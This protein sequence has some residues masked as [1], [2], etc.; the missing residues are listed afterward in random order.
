MKFP[1]SRQFD[2][3]DCGP[4]CIVM[5]S[6]YY[7]KNISI[8]NVRDKAY[9]N[10]NGVNLLGLIDAAHSL[11]F[12][13][14]AKKI[15]MEDLVNIENTPCIL[16][17]NN[18][19]FVVLYKIKKNKY[20]IADP[21]YGKI[22]Y[23]ENELLNNWANNTERKG[24]ILIIKPSAS[25]EKVKSNRLTSFLFLRKY[26]KN[27][28]VLSIQL[29][30]GLLIGSIL[31]LFF[32][33]L[34]QFIV[35]Y[36]IPSKNISF[37]QIILLAQIMLVVSRNIVEIIRRWILLHIST[38]INLSLLSDFLVK[39]MKLSMRFF[40]SKLV[41]DL[42]R[43]IEDHKR[44]E[45]FLTQSI[46]NLFFSLITIAVFSIVLVIYD[47]KIFA[48]FLIGSLL[49]TIWIKLFLKKRAELD[50]K[51]FSQMSENQNSL[52]QLIYGMQEIKLTG[53]EQQKLGEWENI[54]AELFQIKKKSL[55]LNQWLQT[56]AILI[57]EIKNVFITITSAI[58]VINGEITLGGMLSIQYI[59]GQMHGPIEQ[60]VLFI[61]QAQDAHLSLERMG[62]IHNSI[63]EEK[64]FS[65]VH[66][67]PEKADIELKKTFFSYG[68]IKAEPI[69]NNLSLL[70]PY[71]KTTAIVG[72]SGSGKT[73]LIKLLLG[74]YYPQEGSIQ[75]GGICFDKISLQE[76]R[77]HCG[78][79]MQDGYLFN[80]TI[81]KNIAPGDNEIDMD[82][83]NYAIRMASLNDYIDALPQKADTKIGNTGRGLSQ[84]QKQR[85]L[86]ARA[87]YK[88]PEYIFFDEATNALDSE[89]ESVIMRNLNLFFKNKTVVIVAHRLSTVKNADQIVVMKKGTI[90][91]IGTHAALI[92]ERGVY[93]N[94][95]KEQ[96]TLDC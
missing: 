57:N 26:I 54:Q 46:V 10:R 16:H 93:Y 19:H 28:K 67:I 72:L 39:M 11:G 45:T 30:V 9:I 76:W 65:G 8:E 23:S 85:L 38:R 12:E 68:N 69:I 83:I 56:G 2:S 78:V 37:I 32:P 87:I 17:W 14:K 35:D 31:Q 48:I 84:G 58:A 89:N 60:F 88:D 73:T 43:R 36:G 52:L 5:I 7:K 44:I 55:N 15:T 86:I 82:K 70:I 29:V 77:S 62:E 3:S 94:L 96:L 40:D 91:E 34:T 18:K 64:E 24:I 21:A 81:L 92:K 1:T 25:F 13:A 74:F 75:I 61:Q 22:L 95:V 66:E 42:I 4:A 79:V 63:E 90:T 50:H 51:N 53:C 49:Y 27:Y 20:Y 47:I 33:F 59:I 41:G 71:K 6:Q 80:D